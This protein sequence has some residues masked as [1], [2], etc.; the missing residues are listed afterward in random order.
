MMLESAHDIRV[1]ALKQYVYQSEKDETKMLYI[2]RVQQS[3]C[4]LIYD[5]ALRCLY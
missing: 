3:F 1:S 5:T 2:R 4:F